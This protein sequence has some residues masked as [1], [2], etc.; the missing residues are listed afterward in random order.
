MERPWGGGR[1]RVM[2]KNWKNP[3][4]T[5]R[6][7]FFVFAA[8][9]AN[10]CLR[11]TTPFFF[12]FPPAYPHPALGHQFRDLL[13]WNRQTSLPQLFK[14]SARPIGMARAAA[15]IDSLRGHTAVS[16]LEGQRGDASIRKTGWDL[17]GASDPPRRPP[18]GDVSIG[19]GHR[20]KSDHGRAVGQ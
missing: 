17:H 11:W 14:D 10:G 15:L 1:L 5:A 18:S 20:E 16:T 12:F 13:R 2:K 4:S 6:G 9:F 3:R 19:A 7:Q 8:K